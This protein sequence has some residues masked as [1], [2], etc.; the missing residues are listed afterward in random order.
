MDADIASLQREMMAAT[1]KCPEDIRKVVSRAIGINSRQLAETFYASILQQPRAGFYLSHDLVQKRLMAGVRNW[2]T[3]LL[4]D[5]RKD[6]QGTV[7]R[8]LEIGDLHARAFVPVSLIMRGFRDLKTRVLEE[9]EQTRLSREDFAAAA[10]FVASHFDLAL[11]GMMAGH[12]GSMDR[13]ARSDEALRLLTIGQDAAAE[14]E[15]QR[16]ALSEWAQGIFFE[17]HLSGVEGHHPHL[18]DSEFGLWFIHRAALLFASFNEYRLIA[19]L[20]KRIDEVVDGLS[21][22]GPVDQRLAP[23]REIKTLVDN[24]GA[25]L[26]MLFDQLQLTNE[27]HDPLTRLLNRRFLIPAISREIA[28]QEATNGTHPFCAVA[29]RIQN[30]AALN[31]FLGEGPTDQLVRQTASLLFNTS[32]SSDSVFSMQRDAFFVIRVETRADE[33]EQFAR[34]IAER[35][36]AMHIEGNGRGAPAQSL[37]FGVAE[38]DGHPNPRHLIDRAEEALRKED[39]VEA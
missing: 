27:M 28:I 16:A 13:A 12:V 22:D 1:K 21:L 33:A 3:D 31:A 29:F 35:F 19:D 14:R 17:S 18:A 38:F 7:Q 8:Q 30:F 2:L 4:Q 24:I 36:E 26:N 37:L 34:S 25:M 10:R 6:A 11:A 15:K 23:L 20:I 39:R 5:T 32:R 9:V